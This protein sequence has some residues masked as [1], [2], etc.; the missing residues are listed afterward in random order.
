MDKKSIRITINL[1]LYKSK[2]KRKQSHFYCRNYKSGD[3][4]NIDGE[5]WKY[6][7][8][9]NNVYSVSNKGRIKK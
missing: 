8:G 5:E 7:K 6:I 1:D 3:V 9:F 2:N 4:N